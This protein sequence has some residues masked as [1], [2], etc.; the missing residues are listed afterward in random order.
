M[1]QNRPAKRDK[2]YMDVG[3]LKQKSVLN[4]Y[5]RGAQNMTLFSL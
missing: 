3:D 2:A 1:M 4:Q 5:S